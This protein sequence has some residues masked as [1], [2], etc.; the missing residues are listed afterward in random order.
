MIERDK[1]KENYLKA[2]VKWAQ[3]NELCDYCVYPWHDVPCTCGLSNNP[4]VQKAYKISSELIS[5]DDDLDEE[6]SDDTHK[7][8]EI[9]IAG[10]QESIHNYIKEMELEQESLSTS[11]NL[12]HKS[13]KRGEIAGENISLTMHKSLGKDYED[14]DC[15]DG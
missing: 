4:K 10:K 7:K 13:F 1:S 6:F 12:D 9:M 11:A 15:A 8:Y 14:E 2:H 3:R 5:E